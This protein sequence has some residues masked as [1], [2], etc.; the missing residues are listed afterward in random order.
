MNE[1]LPTSFLDG[2]EIPFDRGAIVKLRA[3]RAWAERPVGYAMDIKPL[4][5]EVE[6]LAVDANAIVGTQPQ[7]RRWRGP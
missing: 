7:I 5:L 4:L 3:V 2:G 6:E 1:A